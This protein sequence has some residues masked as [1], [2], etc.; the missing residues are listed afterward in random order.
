VRAQSAAHVVLVVGEALMDIVERPEG[1]KEH[2]GGGPANVSLGLGRLGVPVSLLSHL[3]NDERGAQIASHLR[4]SGV[5]VLEASFVTGPTSVARA[6]LMTNGSVEYEFD[7]VWPALPPAS[8]AGASVMHIGSLGAFL[9]PGADSLLKLARAAKYPVTFDPNIRPALIGTHESALARFRDFA[10]IAQVVKLSDEDARWLFGS[11]DEEAALDEVL[12][13][14]PSLAVLTRGSKGAILA[15][16]NTRVEVPA[17]EAVVVDTI[18]AGD[19]Y[20]AIVVDAVYSGLL[21]GPLT[22]AKLAKLGDEAARAAAVT[23]GRAGAD[24]PRRPEIVGL[25]TTGLRRA[26]RPRVSKPSPMRS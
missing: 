12:H 21:D 19:T 14:G 6:R 15:T 13:F 26:A 16:C 1:T 9:E 11:P 5:D 17:A 3:G 4:A 2:P 10:S 25:V 18:G 7:I 24:L 23:V 20:M 22:E 8:V